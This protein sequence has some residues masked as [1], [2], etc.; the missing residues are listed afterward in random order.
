MW[1]KST[2]IPEK[3]ET[4]L[5]ALVVRQ[6]IAEDKQFWAQCVHYAINEADTTD[7]CVNRAISVADRLLDGALLSGRKEVC[8]EGRISN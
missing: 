2:A 1:G 7:A 4:E 5:L 6:E 3:S 8:D